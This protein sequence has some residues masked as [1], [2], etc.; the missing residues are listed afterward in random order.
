MI[1]RGIV[2]M[3]VVVAVWPWEDP[4]EGAEQGLL[5]PT[6]LGAVTLSCSQRLGHPRPERKE[7]VTADEDARC[8]LHL[9]SIPP[10]RTSASNAIRAV[11]PM[12]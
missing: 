6:V 7:Q 4:S 5:T 12:W 2:V 1:Q 11:V 8:A 10:M 9:V 3:H